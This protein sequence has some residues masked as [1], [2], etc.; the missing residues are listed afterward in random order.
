MEQ[1]IINK[2]NTF[3]DNFEHKDDVVGCLAC[4]SFVTGNPNSHS[5]LDVH[6]ILKDSCDYRERGNRIIDGLLVEYFA[7]TKRQILAYFD[8]DYKSISPMS[9]TQFLTGEIVFDKTG[10]IK[11][12]KEIAAAQMAKRY[13]DISASVSGLGL[14]AIWDSLDDLE[15]MYEDVRSDFEFVYFNRLNML[16]KTYFWTQKT[17]YNLKSILGHIDSETTRRKYLLEEIKDEELKSLIKTCITDRDRKNKLHAFRAIANR[18]L[19]ENNFDIATFSF[20]S[21][22]DI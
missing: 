8:D 19:Q 21:R 11:E 14:Y 5:D 16:L 12:L 3:L 10:E 7:N 1:E 22:E 6:L 4:G 13:E 18:L 15:S 9:H 17:P 20:K 2:L